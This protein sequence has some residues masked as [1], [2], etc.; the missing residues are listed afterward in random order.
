M[1]GDPHAP[2]AHDPD[3]EHRAHDVSMIVALVAEQA[4]YRRIAHLLRTATLQPATFLVLRNGL[5]ERF[6][7]LDVTLPVRK[8]P[9]P[10]W[11]RRSFAADRLEEM[12]EFVE[13]SLL[14]DAPRQ[15]IVARLRSDMARLVPYLPSAAQAYYARAARIRAVTVVEVQRRLAHLDA[16]D[17]AELTQWCT[18]DPAAAA[19]M[20]QATQDLDSELARLTT[21]DESDREVFVRTGRLPRRPQT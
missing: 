10:F 7:D 14:L 5:F 15:S 11:N 18:A 17:A 4:K 8:A 6:F 9:M 13:R 16:A 1:S 3:P 20:V 12:A 21:L 2:G 19:I